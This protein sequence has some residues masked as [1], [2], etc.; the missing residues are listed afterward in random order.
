MDCLGIVESKRIA[1]G[2]VL[3]DLMVKAAD[4]KLVR[5]RPI[6][7][8]RFMIQVAGDTAA[9]TASVQAAES[10]GFALKAGLVVNR[11]DDQV[12]AALA[13]KPLPGILGALGVVEAKTASA[14]IPG[15][16]AAVKAADV[17]LLRIVTGQGINGKS[18]FVLTG[19]VA[20]VTAAVEAACTKL[21][22]ELLDAQVLA[23]PD[24]AVLK[25][26]SLEKI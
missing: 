14:A 15:A 5:A 11:V 20:S 1:A 18:Y 7:S 19:D 25:S 12:I 17:N 24:P 9:V 21:E 26:L 22:N 13:Q 23:S 16:D 4:V 8:G 6:C 3:A 10:G 2:V